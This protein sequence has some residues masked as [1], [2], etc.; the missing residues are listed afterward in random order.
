[1]DTHSSCINSILRDMKTRCENNL[2]D[3]APLE[4]APP[5]LIQ[6]RLESSSESGSD[7]VR[8]TGGTEGRPR[9]EPRTSSSEEWFDACSETEFDDLFHQIRS[10][11]G[12]I[13]YLYGRYTC[14]QARGDIEVRKC[15]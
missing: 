8:S 9:M 7:V 5:G 15:Q 4:A 1:M 3:V 12:K 13:V 2:D 6:R 11:P 14:I 10:T